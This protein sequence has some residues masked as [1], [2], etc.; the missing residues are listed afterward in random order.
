MT[1][2]LKRPG[3][4]LVF[5]AVAGLSFAGEI[6]D[7]AL[8][9]DL[10]KVK[11]LLTHDPA[12]LDAE[13]EPNKKTPLH[14]AAQGGHKDVVEFLLDQGARVSRPNIAGETPL[15]YAAGLESPDVAN[16]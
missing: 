3:F 1:H 5:L 13:N 11:A 16:P 12:L 10:Q 7:A 8:K 14:Y 4:T 15:H 9:G 2:A 6:H